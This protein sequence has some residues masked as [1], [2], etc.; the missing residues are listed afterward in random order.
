MGKKS[1]PKPP[2]PP[3]PRAIAQTDVEFNRIDQTTPFG[4]LRYSGPNRNQATLEFTPEIQ[5]LLDLQTQSDTNL[6]NSAVGAQGNIDELMQNPLNAEG[7]P[8]IQAP[9]FSGLPQLPQDFEPYRAASERAFFDR[10][11]GLLN[12]QFGRQEDSLRQTLANQG[13]QSGGEAFGREF[14]DFNQR[15]G[16]TFSNLARD[17]VLFGGQEASRTLGEQMGLRQQ[18]I[19]E[20]Q[21]GLQNNAAIR[22]QLLG[23]RG[24]LRSN[25][26]NELASLLGLQ[27][28][29]APGLNNF[30]SPGQAGVTDAYGLN[31]ASQMNS[32]NQRSASARAAKGEFGDLLQTAMSSGSKKGG[33]R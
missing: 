20:A 14:G 7:L 15:R 25:Q 32:F 22:S 9:N 29:Q 18:G 30:F 33:A 10:S 11:A 13:L 1:Q 12:E 17:A 23:E 3:D 27:Q 4:T 28:V 24:S 5:N 8:E 6:L 16:E 21:Q 19:G 2:A 26:F 31:Q